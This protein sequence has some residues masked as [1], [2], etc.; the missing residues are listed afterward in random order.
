MVLEEEEEEE[1]EHQ[2]QEPEEKFTKKEEEEKNN[3]YYYPY[4]S[5]PSSPLA[6]IPPQ[7]RP[8]PPPR[9]YSHISPPSHTLEAPSHLFTPPS[10]Q[11][12]TATQAPPTTTLGTLDAATP[13]YYFNLTN[14]ARVFLANG[15]PLALSRVPRSPEE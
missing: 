4:R 9:P 6:N 12:L 13:P 15:Q 3:S 7:R 5:R 1:E 2:E 11:P 10:P 14:Y 8:R